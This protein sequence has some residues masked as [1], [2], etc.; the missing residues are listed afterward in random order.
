[1]PPGPAWMKQWLSATLGAALLLTCLMPEDVEARRRGGGGGY[2]AHGGS[3]HSHHRRST[4]K[5]AHRHA[6]P[7]GQRRSGWRRAARWAAIGAGAAG[8]VA[9]GA[10]GAAALTSGSTIYAIARD[11]NVRSRPSTQAAVLDTLDYGEAVTVRESE[12]PWVE[13][14]T[15]DG[16]S[17][18][19]HADYLSQQDPDESE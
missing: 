1:M 3:H 15:A 11:L 18:Y 13:V 10:A 4:F 12:G 2:N 17:G 14:T 7:H 8:L 19:V 5:R 16:R 6:R 9:L